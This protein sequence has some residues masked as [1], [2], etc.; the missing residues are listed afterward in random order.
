MPFRFSIEGHDMP[1]RMYCLP[2]EVKLKDFVGFLDKV[3]SRKPEVVKALEKAGGDDDAVQAILADH[4]DAD[5][6]LFMHYLDEVRFFT[7]VPEELLGSM[8]AAQVLEIHRQLFKVA[9]YARQPKP[10]KNG[11]FALGLDT[12]Y[13]PEPSLALNGEEKLMGKST[14][15]EFIEAAQWREYGQKVV[16]NDFARIPEMI[17]VLCRKKKN[18]RRE[19]LP[20]DSEELDAFVERRAQRFREDLSMDVASAV[21]FFLTAPFGSLTSSSG[22]SAVERSATRFL[23]MCASGAISSGASSVTSTMS[24]LWSRMERSTVPT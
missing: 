19:P 22:S 7:D 2:H 8:P 24:A 5:T 9:E 3:D 16:G 23:M 1:F 10:L 17:A 20:L 12:F 18:G 13:L 15:Q 21:A 6:Q 14:V 4:P 11:S